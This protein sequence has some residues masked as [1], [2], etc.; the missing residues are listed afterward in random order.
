MCKTIVKKV[1]KYN[2]SPKPERVQHLVEEYAQY[3]RNKSEKHK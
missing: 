3:L 1:A 2:S